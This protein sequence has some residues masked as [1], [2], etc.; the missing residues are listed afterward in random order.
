MHGELDPR[1]AGLVPR[2]LHVPGHAADVRG[3]RAAAVAPAVAVRARLPRAAADRHGGHAGVALL[4]A[5]QGQGAGGAAGA[6]VAQEGK[7]RPVSNQL[8]I[9]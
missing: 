8:I 4:A 7:G 1:H 2:A 3:G 5:H 9:Q 6:H